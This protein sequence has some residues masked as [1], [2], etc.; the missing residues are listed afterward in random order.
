M[1]RDLRVR[2]KWYA[3]KIIQLY[4]RL[5]RTTVAQVI[6]KQVLRSGTS[7]GAQYR[8][9]Q[10]ARSTAEFISKVESALQELEETAYWLELLTEGGIITES[11]LN[12]LADETEQLIAIFVSV[13]KSAKQRR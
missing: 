7:P 12:G 10:R 1:E 4:G 2:T 13:A 11:Q 3:L 8:E 5:P 9:A 6:G